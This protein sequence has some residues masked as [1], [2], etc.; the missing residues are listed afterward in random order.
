MSRKKVIKFLCD[1]REK[2]MKNNI[3]VD[4]NNVNWANFSPKEL[5]KKFIEKS[6]ITVVKIG[7]NLDV[8]DSEGVHLG[9]ADAE[10]L[11]IFF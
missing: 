5:S 8:F 3:G 6:F 9:T 2:E 4:C 11:D 10:L 1:N 7:E